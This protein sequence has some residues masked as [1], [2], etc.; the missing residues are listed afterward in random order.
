MLPF[1]LHVLGLPLA[2]ILSQ[3]QTL[4][5]NKSLTIDLKCV[6]NLLILSSLIQRTSSKTNKSF[7]KKD[8]KSNINIKPAMLISKSFLS[9][10]LKN[11]YLK[12]YKSFF[13]K[14]CK[15]NINIQLKILISKSFYLLS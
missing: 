6:F 2:F 3:D 9:I 8:C 11:F 7:F 5:C 4:R 1:D 14:D 13:K 12:H 15:S 10:I